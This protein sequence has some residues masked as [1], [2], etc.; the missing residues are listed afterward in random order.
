LRITPEVA[1]D[2]EMVWK[3]AE[4]FK[5]HDPPLDEIESLSVEGGPL[6]LE[7]DHALIISDEALN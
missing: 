7:S 3:A 5:Y 1:L 2:E 6:E 4:Y